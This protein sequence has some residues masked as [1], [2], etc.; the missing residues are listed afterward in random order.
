MSTQDVPA[1]HNDTDDNLPPAIRLPLSGRHLIEA[2]AGTGKTWTLTG[3]VL[4]LIVEA[5]YPCDKIIATTFT[6]SAAAEMRQ[7]IRERLQDFYRLLRLVMSNSYAAALME[8]T[9]DEQPQALYQW[10]KDLVAQT[11][12]KL[13]TE[14]VGDPINQHLIKYIATQMFEKPAAVES[15]EAESDH[16]TATDTEEVNTRQTP[17]KVKARLDFRIALQRTSTA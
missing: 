13:L 10:L 12:D 9:P 14:A 1:N 6:R 16:T 8:V 2:S 4:R 7:R 17:P 11:G 15:V 5:G 3:V